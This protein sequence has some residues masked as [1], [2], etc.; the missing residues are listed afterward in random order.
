MIV[1]TDMI[2]FATVSHDL[3]KDYNMD[4]HSTA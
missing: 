2:L 4:M 1:F 3:T